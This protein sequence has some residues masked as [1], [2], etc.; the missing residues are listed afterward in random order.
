MWLKLST[1]R[2]FVLFITILF[3]NFKEGFAQTIEVASIDQSR[4]D[5]NSTNYDSGCT[6]NGTRMINGSLPKLT[7]PAHFGPTG[8]V[9]YKLNFTHTFSNSGSITEASLA[10]FQILFVGADGGRAF[11][12]TLAEKEAI[13]KWSMQPGKV[14]IIAEQPF[15]FQLTNYYGY[16]LTNGNKNPCTAGAGDNTTKLFSGVFGNNTEISQ[17]GDSQ[18]YF[19]VDCFSTVVAKDANNRP[20]IIFHTETRDVLLGDTDFFTKVGSLTNGQDINNS[21]DRAWVNL[22]AWAVNEVI[23]PGNS[24][25]PVTT[26]VSHVCNN[27]DGIITF[28]SPMGLS[29][30]GEHYQYS[31]DGS[32]YQNNPVFT[33][34]GPGIYS[35]SAKT[36]TCPSAQGDK[37][38]LKVLQSSPKG[39]AIPMNCRQPT[40]S[41]HISDLPAFG[42]YSIN[43]QPGSMIAANTSGFTYTD[44]NI[45]PGTY[46]Y[47]VTNANGCTSLP[48]T[49]IH[50]EVP[51]KPLLNSIKLQNA[52]CSDSNGSIA[53]D[54]IGETALS[55]SIDGVTFITKP[56]FKY[57]TSGTYA[58][59]IKDDNACQLEK[60]IHLMKNCVYIPDAF[61]I[62]ND[63][64]N[65]E[66]TVHFEQDKLLIKQMN[67]FNRWGNLIFTKDNFEVTSGDHIWNGKVSKDLGDMFVCTLL[68][69]FDDS[70]EIRFIK[71]VWVMK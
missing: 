9:P 30:K 69:Q 39:L 3:I 8:K 50:V 53:I 37:V 33:N 20:T 16:L 70:Q 57:L 61:T 41:I 51:K 18:G 24:I 44:T 6:L 22:W 38:E 15:S 10:P 7:N 19:V 23:N 42:N 13:K 1:F 46:T 66:L 62:N 54:A 58:I 67:I 56:D 71:E 48:S 17:G 14:V 26:T 11:P 31:I 52:D 34:L 27:P 47:T 28:T 63:N 21:A 12:F 43:R 45:L 29:T 4:F 25:Q 32:N 65:E 2:V 40:T 55:Y 59:I 64:L 5:V 36:T 49:P 60:V 35:V 68:I